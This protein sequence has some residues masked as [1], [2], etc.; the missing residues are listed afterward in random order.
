MRLLLALL[1]LAPTAA[2]QS[3]ASGRVERH[4]E[5]RQYAVEGATLE[6]VTRSL[7]ANA[8]RDAD[9]ARFY[10]LT[11]WTYNAEYVWVERDTGCRAEDVVVRVATTITMPRWTPPRVTPA[12]LVEAWN[13]FVRSL[14]A[15]EREHQRLAEEGAEAIR[16]EI[17]SLRLQTCSGAEA[18]AQHAVARVVETT[19][20]RNR[21]YDERTRHG[22]TEGAV[23][24]PPRRVGSAVGAR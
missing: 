7:H 6:E 24:P 3:G 14:E 8:P 21:E 16:W 19:N 11:Q 22:M 13:R 5:V 18:R 23:W 1:L 17:V 4:A 20:R 2:A 15:H 9:G 10:A 12:G